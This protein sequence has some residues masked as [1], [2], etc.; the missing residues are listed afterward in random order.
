MTTEIQVLTFIQRYVKQN[1][2]AP[3][4]R[5]IGQ[6]TALCS[7]STVLYH[8]RNL[9]E[10]GIITWNEGMSRSI[11]V[12]RPIKGEPQTMFDSLKEKFLAPDGYLCDASKLAAFLAAVQLSDIRDTT[13]WVEY[14]L[15]PAA[16]KGDS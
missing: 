7:T 9:R 6:G 5:E 10:R 16:T 11:R 1:G 2:Y 12:L 8:L 14:L 3:S 4:V 13:E 15:T